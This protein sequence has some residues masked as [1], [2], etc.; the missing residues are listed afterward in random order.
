MTI[1]DAN[2]VAARLF[3][4]LLLCAALG[5]WA[6]GQTDSVRERAPASLGSA[7]HA[8]DFTVR[9]HE[10]AL[11]DV[12]LPEG[13]G[14]TSFLLDW[15]TPQKQYAVLTLRTSDGSVLAWDDPVV[16]VLTHSDRFT[17]ASV[18]LHKL[19]ERAPEKFGA[20]PWV[21]EISVPGQSAGQAEAVRLTTL[22][23]NPYNLQAFVPEK[24]VAS[25]P[26]HIQAQLTN[27][28]TGEW[29]ASST[30]FYV[31]VSFPGEARAPVVLPLRDDG[32]APDT[33]PNDGTYVATFAD[34]ALVGSYKLYFQISDSTRGGQ[35][36]SSVTQYV[37]VVE[38]SA[39]VDAGSDAP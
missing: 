29:I 21:A 16:G 39:A 31:Q 28:Q 32:S 34:T 30:D 36:R 23:E 4:C 1:A 35:N 2:G 7:Q 8:L 22:L 18:S 3:E 33:R 12:Y 25:Q 9:A 26:L 38:A 17:H 11:V 15:D 6:C 20:S 19:R 5:A 24:L 37:Q 13:A 10:T 14:E 27:S